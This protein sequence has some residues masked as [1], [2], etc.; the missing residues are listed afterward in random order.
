[1]EENN[2]YATYFP[3]FYETSALVQHWGLRQYHEWIMGQLYV[4][5]APESGPIFLLL[6]LSFI[7]ICTIYVYGTLLTANENLGLLNKIAALSLVIN[8]VLNLL[9]IPTHKALGAARTLCTTHGVDHEYLRLEKRLGDTE[10]GSTA[11][12]W[13]KNVFLPKRV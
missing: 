10:R 4:T 5:T 11:L 9:L 6:M 8:I 7:P 13:S 3:L 1:M 12:N 2:K